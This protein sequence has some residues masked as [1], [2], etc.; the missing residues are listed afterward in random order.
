LTEAVSDEKLIG[1]TETSPSCEKIAERKII[2]YETRID[3]TVIKVTGERLKT[4]LF[5]KFG[6]VKPRPE[7]IRLVSITKHYVP[8]MILS[9]RY[10][11]D[12]YRKCVYKVKVDRKVL[13]IVLLNHTFSPSQPLDSYEKDKNVIK[14]EGEE[15]LVNDLKTSIILDRSGREVPPSSLPSAPSERNYRKILNE[16]GVKEITDDADLRIIRSKIFKRPKDISRV[17]KELFEVNERATIY[18]PRF[19]VLYRNLKTGEE[20]I[21]EFDG[22]TAERIH[23]TKSPP[24]F[25]EKLA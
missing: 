19:R 23:E 14:L 9:G 2:V 4:Q 17:V 15:R 6:F 8:Y 16:Y 1:S 25:I 21:M 18:S 12:Y 11:I 20:K 24:Q 13:E 5:A 3:P 22:V 7:E 10:F